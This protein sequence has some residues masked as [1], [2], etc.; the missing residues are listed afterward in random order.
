MKDP[1]L[2]QVAKVGMPV[3]NIVSMA[4][5]VESLRLRKLMGPP[6]AKKFLIDHAQII[7]EG[8]KTLFARIEE[9]RKENDNKVD[10]FHEYTSYTLDVLSNSYTFHC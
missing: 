2:C 3:D 5:P 7:T 6:F 9:L 4:S 8:I 1:F 10:V